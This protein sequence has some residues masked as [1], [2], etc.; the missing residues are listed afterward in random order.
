MKQI[1]TGRSAHTLHS[2]QGCFALS[3]TAPS[4]RSV[5]HLNTQVHPHTHLNTLAHIKYNN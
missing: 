4:P 3:S 1:L 2:D 5:T